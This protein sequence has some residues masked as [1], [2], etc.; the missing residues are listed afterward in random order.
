M[1]KAQVCID[2]GDK[3]GLDVRTEWV[4]RGVAFALGPPRVGP[5]AWKGREAPGRWGDAHCGPQPAPELP[6]GRCLQPTCWNIPMTLSHQR[7][8]Q[9]IKEFKKT[10][11]GNDFDSTDCSDSAKLGSVRAYP[12]CA[13]WSARA[14][15]LL[16]V[17]V[18]IPHPQ[19][20]PGESGRVSHTVF[21]AVEENFSKITFLV[22]MPSIL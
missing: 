13:L 20:G 18:H 2:E 3:V 8:S 1:Q 9:R 22:L 17:R 4:R 11:H 15:L 21:N 6:G 19:Q 16:S 14:K 7:G 12:A 10:Y 5:H